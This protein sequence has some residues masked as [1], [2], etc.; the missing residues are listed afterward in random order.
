MKKAFTLIELVIVILVIGILAATIVPR[1][2]TNPLFN[3]SVDLLSKIRY[4]QHLSMINDKYNTDNS[5]WFKD[6]WQIVFNGNRYSIV[7]DQNSTYAR[8]PLNKEK[9]IQDIELK[10]VNTIVLSGDGCNAKSIIS[11]DYLGRP[12]IGSLDGTSSAYTAEGNAGELLQDDCT[13]ELSNDTKTL[14][15]EVISETGYIF[16]R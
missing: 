15:I 14:Y 5:T 2:Q 13:I 7:S 6:R 16:L 3:S 8:D 1:T 11:F 9:K 10:G 12:L 4:T